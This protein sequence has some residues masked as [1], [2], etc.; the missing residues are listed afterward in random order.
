LY[1]P[2][3]LNILYAADSTSICGLGSGLLRLRN[4]NIGAVA[5]GAILRRR[6]VKQDRLRPH[7][8][9]RLVAVAAAHILMG[10][11]Q[12]ER[13]PL[14]VIKQRRFPFHAV[15]ALRATCHIVMREL[16]PVHVLMAIF[17]LH[18]SCLEIHIE[19]FR[20]QV[21]RLV[22]I[23]ASRRAMRAQQSEFRLGMIEPRQLLPRFRNVTGFASGFGSIG[24][25][26]QHALVE[27][28]FVRIVVATLAIQ[29]VP[30]IPGCRLWLKIRRLFVAIRTRNR[31]VSARQH[32]MRLSVLRQR[33]GG[34]LVAIDGV[35][36]VAGV[37]IRRSCELLTMTIRMAIGAAL[38]LHFEHRVLPLRNVTLRALQ[39]RMT[40]H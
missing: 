18:R 3:A 34:R 33:K 27:L 20:F 7:H 40:A 22:A 13:R 38:K 9:G 25:Y 39:P 2:L 4:G 5:S 24:P 12:R 28:P 30:V 29:I 36:T 32:E 37:E 26:L 35:T 21:R 1:N 11:A 14:L 31:D 10:A 8:S 23:D 6:F 16:L 19:Q 17:A 15:V